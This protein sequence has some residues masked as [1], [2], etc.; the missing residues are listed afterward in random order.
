[1]SAKRP[2]LAQAARLVRFAR[3][4]SRCRACPRLVAHREEI[5]RVK[6]R[7]YASEPYWAKPL[8]G[9]GDPAAALVIV[10]LAPGAHGANRTGRVFTGDR[11]GDF[12]YAALH[13]AGLAS[14]P[15][16][17]SAVDG[18]TLRATWITLPCR[19]APPDNRPLPAELAGCRPFF[20]RELELLTS[21]RAVLAL[22][23][24]A[25]Q[26]TLALDPSAERAPFAHGREASIR[27]PGARARSVG[28]V[29]SYHVSQQNT[30][31]GRLTPDMFDAALGRAV[32]LAGVG[33]RKAGRSRV[34][35]AAVNVRRS[36]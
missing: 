31:T 7:A 21:M 22:G 32:S 33:G 27:V 29:A 4:V 8:P 25:Y 36:R 6:R 24:I 30:Q 18:L 5:G 2:P 16:S 19:C 14:Q 17:I 26:A 1:M 28:V 10:G 11:S 15:H 12:L 20:E 3:E 34:E 23:A 35:E 9:F 13:R